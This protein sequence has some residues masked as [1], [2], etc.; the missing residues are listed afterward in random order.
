MTSS[1]RMGDTVRVKDTRGQR[2]SDHAGVVGLSR[3]RSC[4]VKCEDGRHGAC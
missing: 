3:P 1:V 2:W 4:D